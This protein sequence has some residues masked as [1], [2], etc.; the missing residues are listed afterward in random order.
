MDVEGIG[1]SGTNLTRETVDS[2]VIGND[3]LHLDPAADA[4]LLGR[5]PQRTS[6]TFDAIDADVIPVVA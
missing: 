3:L 1:G 6:D 2:L 4:R 5:E